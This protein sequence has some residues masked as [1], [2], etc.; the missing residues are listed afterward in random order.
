[1][2]I[3]LIKQSSFKSIRIYIDF[4]KVYEPTANYS[5]IIRS[6]VEN[7]SLIICCGLIQRIQG[8]VNRHFVNF[9]FDNC[10]YELG[11][12]CLAISLSFSTNLADSD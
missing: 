7:N 4:C 8:A 10:L 2:K 12:S 5:C 11:L 1:M 6:D 9:F 3:R